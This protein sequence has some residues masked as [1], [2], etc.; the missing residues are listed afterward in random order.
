MP[1]TQCFHIIFTSH[2]GAHFSH[3]LGTD[4]KKF[5]GLL[6][7]H[8]LFASLISPHSAVVGLKQVSGVWHCDTIIM[9]C[10]N[11]YLP[12]APAESLS[13][14]NHPKT[15]ASW[16]KGEPSEEASAKLSTKELA[17]LLPN[18]T[19][20]FVYTEDGTQSL[21]EPLKPLL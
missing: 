17:L 13:R 19:F 2:L 14:T 11:I 1:N 8:T 5:Q 12:I 3:L 6:E 4:Q 20:L 21:T 15:W 7:T 10:T 9:T 16:T 18:N